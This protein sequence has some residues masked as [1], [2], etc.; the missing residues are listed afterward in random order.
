M[1][2]MEKVA[3]ML[4]VELGEKFVIEFASWNPFTLTKDGLFDNNEKEKY[5]RLTE[6]LT[7]RNTI[8]RPPFQPK[9]WERYYYPSFEDE[10]LYASHKWNNDTLDRMIQK[11]VGIYKTKLEAIERTK[12]L[13]WNVC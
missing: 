5:E 10:R 7:G 13:G 9:Q 4:G 1:N 12:E 8:L 3:E 11:N 6:L 2:N